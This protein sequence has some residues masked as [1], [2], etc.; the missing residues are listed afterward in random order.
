MARDTRVDYKAKNWWDTH[1]HSDVAEWMNSNK[2]EKPVAVGTWMYDETIECIVHVVRRNVAYGSGDYQD[3]PEI[4]EDRH[5]TFYYLL[6]G[7]PTDPKQPNAGESG[8]YDSIG[9]A[10]EGA[11]SRL[12]G[13]QWSTGLD[14][15]RAE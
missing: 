10:K 4:R 2:T 12:S 8:P 3:P 9:S 11:A 14:V 6:F 13:L 7:T 15:G 5:G 1:M